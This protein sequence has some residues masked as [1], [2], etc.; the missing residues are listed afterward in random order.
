MAYT[1]N[2]FAIGWTS[3]FGQ[4]GTNADLFAIDEGNY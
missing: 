3:M 4:P 1:F 2:G